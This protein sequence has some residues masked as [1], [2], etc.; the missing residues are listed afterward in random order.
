VPQVSPFEYLV[1]PTQATTVSLVERNRRD[2]C[3]RRLA[4]H[5]VIFI[6]AKIW[7]ARTRPAVDPEGW[8]QVAWIV[9]AGMLAFVFVQIGGSLLMF[10]RFLAYRTAKHGRAV[11]LGDV[12]K[13]TDVHPSR[14]RRLKLRLLGVRR[15]EL[16]CIET[17][18]PSGGT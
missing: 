10:R 7:L 18:R 2:P 3:A 1:S 13:P 17:V 14:F 12:L 9:A 11:A 6:A 16:G 4:L 15:Y 8:P 5:A